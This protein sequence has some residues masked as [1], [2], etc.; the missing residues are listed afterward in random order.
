ME[1]NNAQTAVSSLIEKPASEGILVVENRQIKAGGR[2]PAAH[3]EPKNE[4]IGPLLS[5]RP[6]HTQRIEMRQRREWLTNRSYAFT[7]LPNLVFPN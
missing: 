1:G 3:P 5:S 4:P 7:Y 6:A 2:A